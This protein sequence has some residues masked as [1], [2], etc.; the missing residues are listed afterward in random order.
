MKAGACSSFFKTR[1]TFYDL[2]HVFKIHTFIYSYIYTAW[3]ILLGAKVVF[4]EKK[5]ETININIFILINI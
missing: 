1:K 4:Y 2:L 5:K 3:Y